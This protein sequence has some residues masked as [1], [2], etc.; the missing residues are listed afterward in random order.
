[1]L[2]NLFVATMILAT[3]IVMTWWS[4]REAASKF[5]LEPYYKR[6]LSYQRA[7]GDALATSIEFVARD[8][9]LRR[10]LTA[11]N[12]EA[13]RPVIARA[14]EILH[15]SFHPEILAVVD[16]HGDCTATQSSAVRPE[17]AAEMLVFSHLR[18]GISV[19]GQTLLHEGHAYHVAGVPVRNATGEVVGGVLLGV[20]LSRWLTEFQQQTDEVRDRQVRLAIYDKDSLLSISDESYQH[21]LEQAWRSTERHL[22]MGEGA[23]RHEMEI[24]KH[25]VDGYSGL[26]HGTVGSLVLVQR[27][28]EVEEVMR[29]ILGIVGVGGT[30][31]WVWALAVSFFVGRRLTR[32]IHQFIDATSEIAQ[33]H[34]DLT[35]RFSVR[36]SDELGELARNLNRLFDNLQKLAG[37]VQ[38][39]S[40]QVGASSA[41]ISAASKQMLE[42]AKDQAVKIEGSTAAVTELSASIQQVAQNAVEATKVASASGDAAQQAIERMGEIRRTVE[43]AADKIRQL[44]ESVK[45]VGNIVEVIRQI[46]EQTSL[47]ALNASIEAAHAGEQGRGFAVVADEVSSLARRVGQSAKDIEDLIATIKD[48]TGEAVRSMEGGTTEVEGGTSL[49]T[50][51]LKNLQQIAQVISDTAR[52]VQEQAV[53]SDE[54]ARNMDAVQKIA[55]EVLGAS[56]EAVIQGEQLHALAHQLEHS[57]RGFKVERGA[58]DGAR[59]SDGATPA[60]RG[61]PRLPGDDPVRPRLE[62]RTGGGRDKPGRSAQ[63]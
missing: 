16:R 63:G 21:H 59:P 7:L 27:R 42:G 47:L 60:D 18:Q 2:G 1:M 43:E 3:G 15:K 51:T 49:V 25:D 62:A 38:Q 4:A 57:V 36:S 37:E 8:E 23:D 26:T 5:S 22:E 41:Q 61:V 19:R 53:V 20:D 56:E 32:P 58:G 54:I 50:G 40:F 55:G 33:G 31:A 24:Y 14:Q 34:G 29:R 30:A 48:Q 46:S 13:A 45:R 35:R 39:A 9:E 6:Y 10:A 17:Q 11:G 52:Q 28:T 44:G 12:D